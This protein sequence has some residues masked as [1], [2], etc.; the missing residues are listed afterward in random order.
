MTSW[1]I[2]QT[3]NVDITL[4]DGTTYVTG[5]ILMQNFSNP[6]GLVKEGNNLYGNIGV[7]GPLGGSSYTH[8]RP[9]RGP[10][11]WAPS[12]AERSKNPTWIFPAN[13]PT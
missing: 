5:Q 4:S 2:D 6:N 12:K 7:A 13:S 8:T 3:G 1:S 11:G 9:R 10:T